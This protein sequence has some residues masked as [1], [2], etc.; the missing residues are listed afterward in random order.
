MNRMRSW[1]PAVV[2]VF[3]AAPV[4]GQTPGLTIDK[5]PMALQSR[6]FDPAQPPVDMPPLSPREEAE[7]D[8][9]FMSEASVG[10]QARQIDATHA[11]VTVT[12]V[13]VTLRLN[14]TLWLPDK[15][16]RHVFEH[17]RGHRRIS[18]HFYDKADDVAERIAAP[19]MGKQVT[20]GG[21]DL[22]A[23]LNKTLQRMSGE[24]TDE[25]TKEMKPEPAQ[26]RFDALTDHS[27]NAVS[28]ADAL[29]QI[30]REFPPAAR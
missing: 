17:E 14:V 28:A 7:C 10:G 25:Y 18:E 15:V 24:I 9:N 20:I 11:I 13:R 23:E 19:Y 30:F 5:Q 8:S 16:T 29:A 21:G 12:Q 1:F 26:R 6:R 22:R 3:C 2:L 27:R 4:R